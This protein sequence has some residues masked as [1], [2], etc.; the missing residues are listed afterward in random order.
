ME[1]PAALLRGHAASLC[2]CPCVLPIVHD[3]T[4]NA[5]PFIPTAELTRSLR[6][7]CTAPPAGHTSANPSTSTTRGCGWAG[8]HHLSGIS[9][10][11]QAWCEALPTSMPTEIFSGIFT[12]GP[13]QVAGPSQYAVAEPFPIHGGSSGAGTPGNGVSVLPA[14]PHTRD[15]GNQRRLPATAASPGRWC[16]RVDGAAGP[17]E[18]WNRRRHTATVG[19]S[20]FRNNRANPTAPPGSRVQAGGAA[21]TRSPTNRAAHKVCTHFAHYRSRHPSGH[22]V[23]RCEAW[24]SGAAGGPGGGCLPAAPRSTVGGTNDSHT[25]V[26][27]CRRQQPGAAGGRNRPSK[28]PTTQIVVMGFVLLASTR[29]TVPDQGWCRRPTARRA[30]GTWPAS[31]GISQ[32]LARVSVSGG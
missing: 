15:V 23:V 13:F 20:R 26:G 18:D 17:T 22:A 31:R 30:S 19:S 16:R 25:G 3:V 10:T 11:T 1:F 27:R 5:A 28:R 8:E 9:S 14:I 21:A 4:V 12:R 32:P 2:P 24:I 6:E 7:D 29:L